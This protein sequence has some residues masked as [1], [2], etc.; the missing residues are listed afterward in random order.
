MKKLLLLAAAALTVVACKKD[1]DDPTPPN[2]G[3]NGNG[4]G[5]GNNGAQT[6]VPTPVPAGFVKTIEVTGQETST[7]T[8]KVENNL[9]KA[10][11]EVST[12]GTVTRTF[13]YEGKNLK[14]YTLETNVSGQG[15][16][17]TEY[18]FTYQNNKLVNFKRSRDAMSDTY[19]VVVDDK[20]RITSKTVRANL[21]G[22]EG[23]SVWTAT[24]TYTDNALVVKDPQGKTYSYTYE[25]GNVKELKTQTD[26][27]SFN[28]D[29]SLLNDFNFEYFR[30]VAVVEAFVRHSSVQLG[31]GV[32]DAFVKSSKN[33]LTSGGGSIYVYE[34]TEKQGTNK[35][36]TVLKKYAG[37]GTFATIKYTYY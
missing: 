30:W 11:V 33:F 17:K 21:N 32:N 4:N 37:G 7:T 6:E 2:G 26:E 34:V 13:D 20:G 35:P 19:D 5:N 28:Y 10:W 12:E 14:K 25:N 29:T 24:F 23:G 15:Y 18:D 16:L 8:F 31:Q 27:Y 22:W 36:K 3:G 1:S 9:L